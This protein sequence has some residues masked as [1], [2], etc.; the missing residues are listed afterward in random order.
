MKGTKILVLLIQTGTVKAWDLRASTSSVWQYGAGTNA[1]TGLRLTDDSSNVVVAST[2]GSLR[3]L[4]VS[5]KP[6]VQYGLLFVLPEHWYLSFAIKLEYCKLSEWNSVQPKW[7]NLCDLNTYLADEA[8]W[9]RACQQRLWKSFKVLWY[10]WT[11]GYCR[12]VRTRQ[13]SAT[14][15]QLLTAPANK[16]NNVWMVGCL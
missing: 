14:N 4:E 11:I 5:P 16:Q 6:T 7:C 1:I 8:K 13:L 12:E 10:R 2:D 15:W 9:S 3:V